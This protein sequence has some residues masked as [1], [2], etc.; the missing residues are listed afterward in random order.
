MSR[1]DDELG[2]DLDVVEP[3]FPPIVKDAVYLALSR[4]APVLVLSA[5]ADSHD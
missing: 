2:S 3:V 4:T 1:V 5:L